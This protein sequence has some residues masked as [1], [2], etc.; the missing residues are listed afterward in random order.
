M[1]K[2]INR[3]KV[4]NDG[5]FYRVMYKKPYK[6]KGTYKYGIM[7]LKSGYITEVYKANMKAGQVKD[8]Y[9]PSVLGI[10]IIGETSLSDNRREY[11]VWKNILHR[12]YDLTNKDYNSYG[13]KGVRV[14]PD[15]F[16]FENFLNDIKS[17]KGYDYLL[18]KEGKIQLDKD[19]LQ[20]GVGSREK[21]YSKE[22]CVFLSPEQNY[23]LQDYSPFETKFY[24]TNPEGLTRKH[25]GLRPFERKY[26]IDRRGVR[27]C[28]TGELSSYKGW[29]FVKYDNKER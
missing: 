27:K 9:S 11:A 21:I 4:N 18:F 23:S 6:T 13:G 20:K 3:V 25:S 14:S 22:T 19:Y 26:G 1:S 2:T 29:K 5:L 12:C 8:K 15:W 10:G 7:F 16:Y 28:L 24:S 17:I